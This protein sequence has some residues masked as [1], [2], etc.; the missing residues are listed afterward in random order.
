MDAAADGPIRPRKLYEQVLARIEAAIYDGRYAPGDQL[1]SEREL[2]EAYGVGRPSVR[3]ALF[4]LQRM[5]LV[6]VN[7]GE[8]ARVRQPTP[9]SLVSELSGPARHFLAQ[10]DGVRHFQQA[11]VFLEVALA[12]HAAEHA[13]AR[14]IEGLA[15]ALEANR[16]A[17][18]N[19]S[20]QR[21][22]VAFHYVLAQMPRNPIFT[23]LH[24]AMAEWLLEQ[25]TVSLRARGAARAAYR[26][27]ARIY[28]T[29]AAK[30]SEA[31]EAAMRDHLAETEAFYWRVRA[32][33]PSGRSGPREVAA[34]SSRP[35]ATGSGNGSI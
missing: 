18:G 10:Q 2:M 21:T 32:R 27:H 20:F 28:E 5:G 19:E 24:G 17:I 4:A 22:D 16:R 7:S 31:A 11:R 26:A 29:I 33:Q 14:D 35:P 8:R 30:D 1:P 34:A 15:G 13:A 23:A 12:R 25:R 9:E 6:A 3:E